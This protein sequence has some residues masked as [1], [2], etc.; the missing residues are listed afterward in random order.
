MTN[1]PSENDGFWSEVD[2]L[3]IL[4]IQPNTIIKV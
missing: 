3:K 4:Y 1:M 2:H